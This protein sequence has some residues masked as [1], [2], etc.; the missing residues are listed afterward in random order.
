MGAR[1]TL[2]DRGWLSPD[3]AQG[4]Q[5]LAGRR[6]EFAFTDDPPARPLVIGHICSAVTPNSSLPGSRTT[7]AVF[8]TAN[9]LHF[10][11]RCLPHVTA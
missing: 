2:D 3:D 10:S 8:P 6:G 1:F 11:P 7:R 9:C 4:Q 5:A